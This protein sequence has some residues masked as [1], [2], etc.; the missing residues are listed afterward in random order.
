MEVGIV[1]L[2]YTGKTSLFKAL[3][4]QTPDAATAGVKPNV[5][6]API[7]DPRLSILAL[8]I[9]TKKITPATLTVVD[10][11][12]LVRGS[13]EGAGRGNAFLTHIRE[14]D[15]LLH[16]VRCFTKAPGGEQIPHVDGSLD[17]VRDIHTV[18]AE[19]ILADL[20][21]AEGALPRAEKA[22]RQKAPDAAARLSVLQ[23][24]M[25]L[26]SDARPA[27][28]LKLDDPEERKAFRGLS[29]VSGKPVLYVAN[30][31]ED[32]LEGAGPLSSRV[33]AHA[34]EQRAGFVPICARVEA[35]LAELS[36]PDRAELLG[37]LGLKEPG[38]GRLARAAY[39][40]LG[41]QSFYTA[42]EKEVRAWTIPK[43]ATAPQAAG[44]I[45]TDFE[46]GFIRVEVYAVQDLERHKSE[47]AIKEAG[48]MRTEG[49]AYVMR[50]ADVCHFLFN[51]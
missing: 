31:D 24:A 36:E 49:K 28:E 30:V 32:D 21:Q 22:A 19:L 34:A 16:V 20:Q 15:A 11:P 10:I 7:P 29:F 2:P 8:Y 48:R 4:G 39:E 27:R 5:G 18:E 26:L 14:V 9:P 40:L 43:G 35:E 47:K 51:T 38:L 45:H 44:A 13:S 50:D 33:A 37:S 17:P 3:T 1:G 6:V 42:G 46:R 12:G 25:P 23:Q 41:L